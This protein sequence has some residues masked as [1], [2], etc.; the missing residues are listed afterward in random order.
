MTSSQEESTLISPFFFFNLY[1]FYLYIYD[2]FYCTYSSREEFCVKYPKRIA[3]SERDFASSTLNV[4][5][6]TW[7]TYY[8]NNDS[9]GNKLKQH[10]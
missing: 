6:A 3:N 8:S 9:G 1:F 4:F 2:C 5:L 10:I 7:G